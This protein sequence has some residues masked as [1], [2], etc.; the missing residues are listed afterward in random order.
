MPGE[1]SLEPQPCRH[2]YWQLAVCLPT[3][4]FQCGLYHNTNHRGKRV[5][6]KVIHIAENG[7]GPLTPDVTETGFGGP[8]AV[9]ESEGV[10]DICLW[11]FAFA[12]TGKVKSVLMICV[13]LQVQRI[14]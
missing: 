6:V 12:V 14:S 8:M 4:A 5:S 7:S 3:L 9:R 1:A 2:L 11:G 10:V 13:C